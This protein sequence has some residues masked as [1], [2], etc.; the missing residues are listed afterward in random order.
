M[1][2]ALNEEIVAELQL[3]LQTNAMAYSFAHKIYEVSR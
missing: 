2:I 1:N 3:S